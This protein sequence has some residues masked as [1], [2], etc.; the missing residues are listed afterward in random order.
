EW[1][2]LGLDSLLVLLPLDQLRRSDLPAPLRLL[3]DARSADVLVRTL[4]AYL[5]AGGEGLLH[6]RVTVRLRGLSDRCGHDCFEFDRGQP[7]QCELTASTVVGAFDPG[8]DGNA[9]LLAGV[10][11]AAVQDVLLQQAKEALHGRVVTG[12]PDAAHRA[13]DVTTA[14]HRAGQRCGG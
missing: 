4:D 8:D 11:A 12:G 6:E 13:G 2:S 9:Q 14:R 5:T 1:E 7:P 3:F 10:P